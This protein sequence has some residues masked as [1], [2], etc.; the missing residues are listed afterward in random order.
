MSTD[1]ERLKLSAALSIASCH[2][3]LTPSS[4]RASCPPERRITWRKWWEIR[5]KDDYARY[6]RDNFEHFK[7]KTETEPCS[8][9]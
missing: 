8:T 7:P 4:K 5:Y 1:L 3:E 6:V 9:K 2:R